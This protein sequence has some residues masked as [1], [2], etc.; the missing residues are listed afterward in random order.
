MEYILY[1]TRFLYRIR[2]WLIIGT[3]IITTAAYFLGK[4]MIGKTYYT[5]ATLYTGVASGYDLESGGNKVDWAT[6]QNAMDNL[7]NI[8]KA[9]STLKRV[10]MR[11][12]A[13]CL[14][15]G[16]PDNDNEYIKASNYRY[17]YNHLKNSKNGKEI[18]ALIDK[19]SEKRTVENFT[20]YLQ[21]TQSNY[22]YG[23]FYYR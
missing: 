9:E 14:I 7:M 2:W 15:N 11:L 22:L 4:R 19:T 3:I 21:P 6:A 13:R 23:V 8:I 17:I 5:E 18:L 16:D 10:S 20:R 12:Y 1:I